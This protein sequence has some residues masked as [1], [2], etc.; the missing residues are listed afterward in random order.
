MSLL[1]GRKISKGLP[2]VKLYA[3]D[4][5]STLE[6]IRKIIEYPDGE[7]IVYVMFSSGIR[8]SAWDYLRCF[9]KIN[10]L[11]TPCS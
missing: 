1:R 4:R 7:S 10:D 2:K 11:S 8:A 9:V 5:A 3:D 6:E